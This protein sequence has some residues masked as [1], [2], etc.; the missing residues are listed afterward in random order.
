MRFVIPETKRY[1]LK[2]AT[3]WIEVK[4]ELTAGE[5]K[6]Y[7][8][9]GLSRMTGAGTDQAAIDVNW[10]L[11]SMARVQTYLYAWSEKRPLTP[12]AVED[13]STD[14][15]EEIDALIVKHID[16]VKAEKE[17]AAKNALTATATS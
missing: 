4:K 13:L 14:D 12:T 9:A 17:E 6:K 7:R 2:N 5:D 15:F 16:A 3:D 10:T 8:T 1:Y 11:M